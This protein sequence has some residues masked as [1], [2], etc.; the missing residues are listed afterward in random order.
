MVRRE[1]IV[2]PTRADLPFSSA[3]RAGDFIFVSGT[4]GTVD[5]Q[6]NPTKGIEAQ[7]TQC[8][9]NISQV[10]Q[11]AGAALSDVVKATVFLCNADDF[12]KM[13]EVYLKYFPEARPTRSTIITGLVRPD[14]QIEIECIVYK[15]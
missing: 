1:F 3:V 11:T 15:P 6:G 14:M 7:T 13:N 8:L 10:L 12:A 2:H 5:A 9:E 4:T